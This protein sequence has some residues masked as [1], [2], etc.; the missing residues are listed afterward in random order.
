[1]YYFS[2]FLIFGALASTATAYTCEEHPDCRERICQIYNDLCPPN[3]L[4]EP[5]DGESHEGAWYQCHEPLQVFET[6]D[7]YGCGAGGTCQDVANGTVFCT[8]NTMVIPAGEACS[9]S[10]PLSCS[11]MQEPKQCHETAECTTD[12]A[13]QFC[14]CPDGH[15]K[16]AMVACDPPPLLQQLQAPPSL[17]DCSM[18]GSDKTCDFIPERNYQEGCLCNGQP[19]LPEYPCHTTAT[20]PTSC[21]GYCLGTASICF[22]E[23]GIPVCRCTDGGKVERD[24]S[25]V[26]DRTDSFTP[27]EGGCTYNVC[28]KGANCHYAEN[29]GYICTCSDNGRLISHFTDCTP[30]ETR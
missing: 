2:G 29:E 21:A 27:F 16:P 19:V 10:E 15:L 8:C 9:P 6:C 25:C 24:S 11:D 4:C 20:T 22:M 28:G 17:F 7:S 30:G 26:K 18:C 1:M 23:H 5:L 13:V 12:G 14:V 3:F